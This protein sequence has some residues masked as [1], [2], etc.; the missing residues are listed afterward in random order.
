MG[1][2]LLHRRIE[3]HIDA[4]RGGYDLRH[5]TAGPRTRKVDGLALVLNLLRCTNSR[6][7]RLDHA[8]G[9]LLHTVEVGEG[10]VRLHGRELGVV[11]EVHALVA[12]DAADLKH[13]LV[14]THSRRF[15]CSS[16]AMRR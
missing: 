9:E 3:R 11:R 10:A 5:G 1:A 2:Q 15:K 4:Q 12:E 13:T 14:A 6:G 16:V 7:G 8:L